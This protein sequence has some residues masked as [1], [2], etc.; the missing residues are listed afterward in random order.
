MDLAHILS[1]Q[2]PTHAA[3]S[4]KIKRS[5]SGSPQ[6]RSP[7]QEL[8][9]YTLPNIHDA[10]PDTHLL[11]PEVSSTDYGSSS[12]FYQ[13]YPLSIDFASEPHAINFNFQDRNEQ[14]AHEPSQHLGQQIPQS[15]RH[16]T[17]SE[18]APRHPPPQ[19]RDPNLPIEQTHHQ[20]SPH[21][22]HDTAIPSDFDA[23]SD[24]SLDSLFGEPLA[25]MPPP[26]NTNPSQKRPHSTHTPNGAPGPST[27]DQSGSPYRQKKPRNATTSSAPV[28]SISLLD[29]ET[30]PVASRV[31]S[32]QRT[33]QITSQPT[34]KH[35]SSTSSAGTL[36]T[37]T[38]PE[39]K[40]P[41]KLTSMQCTICMDY[42]H[43]LTSTTCGHT[44]C[45]ECI[46]GWLVAPDARGQRARNCPT[47]RMALASK[48]VGGRAGKGAKGG[49]VALELMVRRR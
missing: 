16:A 6:P 25:A 36:P 45:R 22:H 38:D 13:T 29:E 24:S 10:F 12:P 8:Q 41:T 30:N 32:Q 47:C 14:E 35:T 39:P 33:D 18:R 42:P 15:L 23:L 37:T 4:R 40:P 26:S 2:E 19:S 48:G 7:L 11:H 5:R 20:S 1:F 17:P 44:F 21:F 28:Q 9:D 49:C 3:P 27:F 46:Q 43:E 31:L 34:H